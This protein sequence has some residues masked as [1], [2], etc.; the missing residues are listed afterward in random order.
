MSALLVADDERYLYT[1]KHTHIFF[2]KNVELTLENKSRCTSIINSSI[3]QLLT[4]CL[5]LNLK[6]Y[7]LLSY[8]KAAVPS[9]AL[10]IFHPASIRLCQCIVGLS[11]T[12]YSL[13]AMK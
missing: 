8:W 4:Y 5:Q 2:R 9:L 3:D 12:V 7:K 6:V 11:V 10:L 1:H 13:Q